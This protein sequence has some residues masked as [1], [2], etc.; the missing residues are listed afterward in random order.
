MTAPIA[1]PA[2]QGARSGLPADVTAVNQ[3]AQIGQFLVTH[4]IT[5]VYAGNEIVTPA[6]NTG[7]GYGGIDWISLGAYNVDQPFTMPAGKTAAGRVTLP[8]SPV[9]SG[10]DVIVSLRQDA[11]GIPGAVIA[12]TII[13]AAHL[14]QL[15]APS[16]LASGGPLATAQSNTLRLGDMTAGTWAVP[17]EA[18]SGSNP[19][20]ASSGNYFI[21]STSENGT[22][23][24]FFTVAWPGGTAPGP[25]L[26]QPQITTGTDSGTLIA[27][28]DTLVYAGGYTGATLT[29]ITGNTWTAG[30]SPASGQ[31]QAW[32]S[33][34]ALPH[35]VASAGGACNPATDTVYVLGGND[36][37]GFP[38]ANCWHAQVSNSQLGAWKAGPPLPAA[39]A[40]VIAAVV[41]GWLI[42]AGGISSATGLQSSQTWIAPVAADGTP[43]AW[44]PGPPM[45]ETAY[46]SDGSAY[47]VTPA[48]LVVLT[49]PSLSPVVMTLTVT[50]D[51]PGQWQSQVLSTSVIIDNPV[52]L[53]VGAFPTAGGEYELLVLDPGSGVYSSAVLSPVP[54]ISVP[55]PA[56]GLTPGSTYH[57]LLQQA[58]GDAAS[59]VQTAL[60]PG[61]LAA[62]AKT[63]PA[64]G[65]SW[66]GLAYTYSLLASVWDQAPGGP[67]LHLWQ[68]SG[69]QVTSFTWAS[70]SGQLLGVAE[71]TVFPSG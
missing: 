67:P 37:T 44:Q 5:P 36:V 48:G 33:Q 57:I 29:T 8:L 17:A 11:G 60:D 63:Q 25:V 46:S 70:A 23:L 66:T 53:P 58:G 39:E 24:Y 38:V 2:Y 41:N 26:P 52:L 51:G 50:A 16:G 47:A 65:G 40:G 35:P 10:A 34:A 68:D 3:A 6:G 49:W 7:F 31:V 59:Y 42:A 62:A 71:S 1:D 32:S 13:P 54:A 61:A 20:N 27:T 30:W 12:S 64:G 69:A 22:P 18:G 21:L 9:G 4:G 15:A 43:G 28:P 19:S 56:T 45:P 14:L 55:L